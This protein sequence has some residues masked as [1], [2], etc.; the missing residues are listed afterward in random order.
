MTMNTLT[1]IL[2]L[3]TMVTYISTAPYIV[4]NDDDGNNG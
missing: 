4:D 2:L 1:S 3:V